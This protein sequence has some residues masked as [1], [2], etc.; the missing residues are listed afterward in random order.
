MRLKMIL[1]FA[2]LLTFQQG[3]SQQPVISGIIT[4]YKGM[5]V[6]G[7]NIYITGSLEGTTSG[8]D[9]RFSFATTYT[10]S[11]TLGV[12]YIGYKDYRLTARVTEMGTL[13]IIL[14]S[15]D[16]NLSEVVVRASTFSL[17]KSRTL[18]KLDALDVVMTGS[19]NGDIYGALMALPGTQ[20]VGEDGKLYIR[21]GDNRETQTFIDGMHVLNPYS[22]TAQDMPA[23]G[24]FSPFLFQGINF[25]LGGYES[26]FGQAL[27][28]VLPM[29]TKDVAGSTKAG[30]NASPLSI[31]GGGS[32]A[33]K[34][35]SLSGNVNY[36]NLG[37]YNQFLPDRYTWKKP[38]QSISAEAQYK[39]APGP[40]SLFKL[41]TAYDRT[42]FIR[43][44]ADTLNDVPLRDFNLHQDNYYLNATLKTKLRHNTRLFLG[45]AF[46]YVD[47]H[48]GSA[49]FQGD[50]YRQKENEWH[51]KAKLERTIVPAYRLSTGVEAYLKGYQTV[52]H[53]TVQQLLQ[54]RQLNNQLYA[55][56][57]DNQIRLLHGL[58]ANV[59]GRLE[60]TQFNHAWNLS[61]RISLNY[62]ADKF[63]VSAIYGKYYQTPDNTVLAAPH[64]DL[65]QSLATHY[66]LGASWDFNGRLLKAEAY[67]KSYDQ[68]ELLRQ[69]VYTSEG[70]GKSA[71]FDI[72]YSDE[73]SVKRLK[74]NVSYSFNDA[75]RLYRDFPVMSTPLFASRHNARMSFKYHF[76]LIKTYAGFTGTYAS[77]RPYHNPNTPGFINA[78]DKAYFSLDANLT[79]LLSPRVILYTSMGNLTGRANTYGYRYAPSPDSKGV[80]AGE[81]VMA[82]RS[83]F[84][85]L[86]LFISLKSSSAYDVSSF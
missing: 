49:K 21:G 25:S 26:E 8:K 43:T 31:G 83:R 53:D 4:N 7:A 54:D 71:G 82:S 3:Y 84:F 10:G 75:A 81:P 35:S 39:T 40:R 61:P 34:K 48:Y 63:Q 72:Y 47:S 5:P 58:Y 28:A 6:E 22:I 44:F 1:F 68:L 38:Y 67:Y 30:V 41:Y 74:Y 51:I 23:R 62:L 11:V 2:L 45:A 42:A 73:T 65:Q 85:Y 24:R 56:F 36:L 37:L 46:S 52:Y 12:S 77:G 19:S 59:S 9:G 33:F 60:Y 15:Q 32:V 18:E 57:V 29:D 79:F 55:A 70:Y 80:Y 14:Q 69:Q 16:K 78:I 20:K 50:D 66:I 76:P 13:S 17:G 86:G 64:Q 27:S